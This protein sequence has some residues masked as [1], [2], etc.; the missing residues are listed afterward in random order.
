M[1][2]YDTP[3]V[4][5]YSYGLGWF[6]ET[7]RG[8]PLIHHGGTTNDFKSIVSFMPEQDCVVAVL[9]NQNNSQL[10][11]FVQRLVADAVLGADSYDWQ[12]F[13][14]GIVADR[15][16]RVQQ[17]YRT[18]IARRRPLLPPGCAGTYAH[19]ACQINAVA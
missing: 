2:P 15:R 6:V 3:F 19:P 17:E 9:V 12:D 5:E 7:Y 11:S 1:G 18:L 13:F 16:A 14:L 4:D 10:P 8:V